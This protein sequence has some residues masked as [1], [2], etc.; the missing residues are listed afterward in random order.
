VK[1]TGH[2]Q[3]NQ[4]ISS[5]G[6]IEYQEF[7]PAADAGDGLFLDQA[8]ELWNRGFRDRSRPVDLGA[9]QGLSGDA[10]CDQIPS[11]G[12]NFGQFWHEKSFF[13]CNLGC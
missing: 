1:P 10:G 2:A 12:F 5:S 6:K 8:A 4:Q 9:H 13:G 3:V 11:D 7:P